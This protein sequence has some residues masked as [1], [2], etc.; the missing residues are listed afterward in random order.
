[1]KIKSCRSCKSTNIKKVFD[2]GSQKLSGIFPNTKDQIKIPS[3]SLSMVFC[4]K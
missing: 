2:L 4:E 1:M 3:G